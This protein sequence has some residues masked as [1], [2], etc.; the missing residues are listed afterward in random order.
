M[1]FFPVMFFGMG[2]SNPL[3][4][5]FAMLT[6]FFYVF[7]DSYGWAI[8]F[9]AIVL[10]G[11][12]IPLNLRSQ[13]SIT[14]QQAM[15]SK[16][17]EIKREYAGDKAKQDE[18]IAKM[19]KE[20]GAGGMFGGCILMIIPMLIIFP[21]IS[22]VRAPMV[23]L[24]E[25]DRNDMV[26]IGE[27]L[28][29]YDGDVISEAQ[30]KNASNDNIVIIQK[31]ENHPDALRKAVDEGKLKMGQVIDMDFL[32]LNLSTTPSMRPDKLFGEERSTYLPLLGMGIFYLL[33][34]A[35]HMWLTAV[36]RPNYKAD[37]EAKALAKNNPARAEQVSKTPS[38]GTSKGMMGFTVIMSL[39]FTF[40]QPSA[41]G[42]YWIAS[43]LVRIVQQV[44]TY[45]M[46]TKPFELKKAEMA[47]IKSIAFTKGIKTAEQ[48]ALE[49]NQPKQKKNK[50]NVNE[51]T[52]AESEDEN[53]K[54]PDEYK[55]QKRKK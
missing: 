45:Y 40:S 31:L 50:K 10:N 26:A 28:R 42:L 46:Y 34:S 39:W 2:G 37:K 19:M 51:N 29:E 7:F 32:G 38:A 9:L 27:I 55:R 48:M 24:T 53:K 6:R 14:K 33:T 3:T 11:I 44:I 36:M 5:F 8:I 15:S 17:A 47:A 43:N 52:D 1:D 21:L 13:K 25:V 18:E 12:M 54:K 23:H 49:A 35:A 30:A 20:Q 22:I 41:M 16:T 4:N